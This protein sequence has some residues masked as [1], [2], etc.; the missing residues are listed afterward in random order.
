MKATRWITLAVVG[1][2]VALAIARGAQ[3]HLAGTTARVQVGLVYDPSTPAERMFVREAYESV[4]QEEGIPHEWV[5]TPDV[6]L[7]GGAETVGRFAALVFPDGLAQRLPTG[8]LDRAREYL[9]AGGSIAVVYDPGTRESSGAFRSG[10]LLAE[11]VGVQYLRYATLR[12]QAYRRGSIRFNDAR[13]AERW[14]VPAGKLRNGR[15]LTGYE[16]GGLVYPMTAAE[17]TDPDVETFATDSGEPVLSVRRYGRGQALWVNLP[18]GYLKA[19]SDDFL[20]RQVLRTFLYDFVSMPHLVPSPR[21]VG[22]LVINWHLDSR[23]EMDGI[24]ALLRFGLVRPDLRQDFHVTAGPDRDRP[25]DNLG[26]DACG[27][28]AALLRQLVPFGGFGSHGGW[29]HNWF[30]EGLEANRF[31]ESEIEQLIR[32]NNECLARVVGGPIRAYAAPAGVHPQPVATQVLER[33]GMLAYYYTGDS[34]SSPNR[35]FFD[36]KMVSRKVWAFPVTP[37]GRYASVAEMVEGGLSSAEI[38]A[39]LQGLLDYTMAE[40]SIR[41]MYSHGYDMLEPIS[42]E[43]FQRFVARAAGLQARGLLSVDTMVAFAEFLERFLK[44]E[45]TFE[46]VDGEL[47]VSLA[48]PSGLR[49]IAFAVPASWVPAEFPVPAGLTRVTGVHGYYI[50]A[51]QS[52]ETRYRAG[53]PLVERRART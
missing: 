23:V 20:L 51:V 29:A 6:L 50:F 43:P 8:I 1:V 22:G 16:Y 45:Y 25:G 10:G 52:N 30:S 11:L 34:G 44:T 7:R 28:G 12:E 3:L 15:L 36:G 21:G 17:V 24:P 5:S 48:N 47:V 2:L 41:L 33:L 13:A 35:T 49:G 38:D 19:Y 27:R 31:S 39:W 53:I 37:N 40:R 9:Q 26:F 18:L 32:R 46:R 4:L 14:R 42:R